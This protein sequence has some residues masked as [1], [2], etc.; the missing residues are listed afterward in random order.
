MAEGHRGRLKE[1]F[2]ND[3]LDRFNEINALELLLFYTIPRQDTNPVAHACL[4]GSAVFQPC[5]TRIMTISSK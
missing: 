5:S 3:G 1:R 4:T 2:K